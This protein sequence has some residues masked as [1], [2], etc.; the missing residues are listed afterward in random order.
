MLPRSLHTTTVPFALLSLCP[1]LVPSRHCSLH[2]T[3]PFTLLLPSTIVPFTLHT[4]PFAL[5]FD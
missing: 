5:L 3:G 2:T 1:Y 4:G